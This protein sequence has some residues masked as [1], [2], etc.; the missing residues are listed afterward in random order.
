[1][2]RPTPPASLPEW[3]AAPQG[4]ASPAPGYDAWLAQDIAT[5][6]ADLNAGRFASLTDIRKEFG[7]E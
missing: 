4:D 1:M 3:T 5:G 7:L 6:L 2:N